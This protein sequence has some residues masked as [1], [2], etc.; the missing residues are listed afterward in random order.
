MNDGTE[1]KDDT[2][3]NDDCIFC[4]IGRKE[5]PAKLIYDDAEIFAFEDIH[6]Q[7]PIH[8]LI[9]PRKH[10]VSVNDAAD[11]DAAMLGK[12]LLVAKLLAG[13]RGISSGYRVVIN[14]GAEA[15][16]SVDH[17]HV[18]VLGGRAMRW[19]PG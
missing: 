2:A 3:M 9:S 7:A 16:Q 14:N 11:A 12:M 8:L 19:P 1:L 10:L 6:P 4:K 15:G 18:H 13:E 5:I 17:L